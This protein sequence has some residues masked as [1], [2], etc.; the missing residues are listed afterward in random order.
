[1]NVQDLRDF[2]LSLPGATE[3]VKWGKD[4]C[5]SVGAKMFCVTGFEPD[6][7]VTLKVPDDEFG[8]LCEIEGFGPAPYV[9][10]YKWVVIDSF[11]RLS[12]EDWKRHIRQSYDLIVSKLPAKDRPK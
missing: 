7:G 9:G 11:D 6:C 2:C 3:D 1:M 5:F 10:R 8:R 4:L 12:D